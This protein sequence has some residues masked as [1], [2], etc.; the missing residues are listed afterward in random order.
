[1]SKHRSVEEL[2]AM[3]DGEAPEVLGDEYPEILDEHPHR[4]HV[5]D[6]PGDIQIEDERPNN[7][8]SPFRND[9]DV[10]VE[11]IEKAA[12]GPAGQVL[13][14]FDQTF[15]V[16]Q[17]EHAQTAAAAP[18]VRTNQPPS[19]TGAILGGN[20]TLQITP[21]A[22][23]GGNVADP[24]QEVCAWMGASDAETTPVTITLSAVG[25]IV[26]KS[27]PAV[28]PIR[29]YAIV[30]VGTR[31]V[32]IPIR[33]DIGTGCQFTV[34]GSQVRVQVALDA[35]S[36]DYTSLNAFPQVIFTAMMSF[37]VTQK[38][39]PV[40]CTQYINSLNNGANSAVFTIPRLAKTLQIATE[41]KGNT[42][43]VG[44]ADSAL[45]D[46]NVYDASSTTPPI[47]LPGDAAAVQIHNNGPN[48]SSLRLIYE[49]S[50]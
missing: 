47:V 34:S 24:I 43:Q 32:L 38:Q 27:Q 7:S 44:I 35:Q 3:F 6:S 4:V 33:V 31:G 25:N 13:D 9:W 42:F 1:M 41:N 50:L 28:A 48:P 45:N 37:L 18:F 49:L 8:N 26:P 10:D 20:A 39:T 46:S 16:R 22:A 12:I 2:N 19:A 15:Q 11:R 21:P 14:D 30:S 36:L 5:V 40:T 23:V 17:A 29:S